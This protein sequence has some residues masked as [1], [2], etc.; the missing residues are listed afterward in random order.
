VVG[1][2]VKRLGASRLD[3][4]TERKDFD[5][6]IEA[7]ELERSE[8]DNISVPDVALTCSRKAPN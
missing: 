6:L 3:E 5:D 7:A 4:F 1:R 2:L 8:L